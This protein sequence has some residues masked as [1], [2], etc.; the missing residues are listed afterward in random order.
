MVENK[1]QVTQDVISNQ[2]M[3]FIF[4]NLKAP[5]LVSI[6]KCEDP[7]NSSPFRSHREINKITQINARYEMTETGGTRWTQTGSLSARGQLNLT[8]GKNFKICFKPT[9]SNISG[10]R[11][12]PLY[13]L[14][15]TA[16]FI[17]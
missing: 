17:S 11:V 7:L 2:I 8:E 14:P 5:E 1:F 15:H 9:S 12:F 4:L 3:C 13:P 10:N 16:S 6:K